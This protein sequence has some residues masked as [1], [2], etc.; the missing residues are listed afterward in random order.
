MKEKREIVLGCR[1]HEKIDPRSASSS[2]CSCQAA[3]RGSRANAPR[4]LALPGIAGLPWLAGD[5]A[6]GHFVLGC[7]D[8]SQI[9]HHQLPNLDDV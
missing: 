3:E 6:F 8:E 4:G 2:S 5:K 9:H 7:S 1:G